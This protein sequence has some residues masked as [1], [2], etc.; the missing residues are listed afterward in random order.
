MTALPSEAEVYLTSGFCPNAG[1]VI[2]D[3]VLTVQGHPE[4]TR[5]YA[6]TLMN[7]RRAL[8]GMPTSRVSRRSKA[9]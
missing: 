3:H 4:F 5:D 6:R 2:G 9:T 7:H 8:L 1:F